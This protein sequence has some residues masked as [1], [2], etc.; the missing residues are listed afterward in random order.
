[1]RRALRRTCASQ[2][3]GGRRASGGCVIAAVQVSCTR[4]SAWDGS[5]TSWLASPRNQPA[6]ANR[7]SISGDEFRAISPIYAADSRSLVGS[8]RGGGFRLFLG[9][10]ARLLEREVVDVQRGSATRILF[11]LDGGHVT[12]T[13]GSSLSPA[14]VSELVVAAQPHA[15][16]V[17]PTGTPPGDV[18]FYCGY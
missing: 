4:S 12:A 3:R 11:K 14:V 6:C 17:A 1:M 9:S 13:F 8:G 16:T 10:P 18:T 5:C 7:A 2:G 15:L